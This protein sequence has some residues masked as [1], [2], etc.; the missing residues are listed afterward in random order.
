MQ[1]S[2]WAAHS[3]AGIKTFGLSPYQSWWSMTAQEAFEGYGT[4]EPISKVLH[5]LA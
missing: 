2:P 1:L 5:G 4:Q 3:D